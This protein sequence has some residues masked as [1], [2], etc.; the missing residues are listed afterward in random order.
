MIQL[1]EIQTCNELR[2]DNRQADTL[3]FQYFD[4]CCGAYIR[5]GR[6]ETQIAV[7]P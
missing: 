1:F 4:T 7:M 5:T 3:S 2:L 6:A